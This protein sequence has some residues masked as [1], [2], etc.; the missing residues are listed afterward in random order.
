MSDKKMPLSR[1]LNELR[2]RLLLSLVSVIIFALICFLHWPK[3]I[4]AILLE[5]INFVFI[6]PQEAFF[7]RI[8]VAA[9]CGVLLATPFI[10]YQV[11]EF[12]KPALTD[13]ER[14]I[15]AV[16]VTAS[17]FLLFFAI[18]FNVFIVTPIVA[19]IFIKT[20]QPTL[21]PLISV[22]SYT[23]FLLN[24]TIAFAVV[25]QFPV[26]MVISA[27]LGIVSEDTLRNCRKLSIVAIFTVAAI[28][29]PPDAFSQ[30]ALALP[31]WGLYELGL[32]LIKIFCKIKRA[33]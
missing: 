16:L 22:S 23:S 15:A 9:I 21:T 20:A 5:E 19:K 31:M 33:G 12:I 1:H 32:I 3:I 6:S 10:L 18:Y 26:L 25:S 7:T 17:I 14:R 13:D 29:T 27:M 30:L 11:W 2:F 8:K 24:M 4:N 28:I